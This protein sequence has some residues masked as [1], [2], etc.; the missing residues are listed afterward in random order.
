[1]LAGLHYLNPWPTGFIQWSDQDEGLV[2]NS[3]W[4]AQ[5]ARAPFPTAKALLISGRRCRESEP[6]LDW[7]LGYNVNIHRFGLVTAREQLRLTCIPRCVRVGIEA[8]ARWAVRPMT[9]RISG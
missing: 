5:G 2:G 9:S 8:L 4:R 1:M 6:A 7:R 3:H